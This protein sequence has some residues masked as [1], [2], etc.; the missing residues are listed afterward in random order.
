MS[1]DWKRSLEQNLKYTHNIEG[2][3]SG[4]K[5]PRESKGEGP[6]MQP[7]IRS[8]SIK[9]LGRKEKNLQNK[10]RGSQGD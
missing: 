7:A 6:R 9:R 5:L 10:I 8:F 1:S 4:V 2:P 3:W